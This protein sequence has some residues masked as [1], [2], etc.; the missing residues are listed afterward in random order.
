MKKIDIKLNGGNGPLFIWLSKVVFVVIAV[1]VGYL[2]IS[3]FQGG[4]RITARNIIRKTAQ[5]FYDDSSAV[6]TQDIWR[7]VMCIDKY[8]QPVTREQVRLIKKTPPRENIFLSIGIPTI[9]RNNNGKK[10]DYLNTTLS[11]LISKLSPA[12]RRQV[13]IVIFCADQDP[14]KQQVTIANLQQNFQK[15]IQ[16][17]LIQILLAPKR[18]YSRIDNL[19]RNF[20]DTELRVK[21]RSKQS[22]DIAFMFY[23]MHGLSEFYLHL[24]DDVKTEDDFFETIRHDSKEKFKTEWVMIMYFKMGFI[25]KLIKS[26][27]LSPMADFL[28]N[29]YYEM[30]PDWLYSIFVKLLEKNGVELIGSRTL[31]HHLGVQSSSGNTRK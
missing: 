30:P 5:I 14:K 16:T 8:G 2:L 19:P 9:E 3:S 24:E 21:W 7:G 10:V 15:H 17:G 26:D 23:Y 25:G 12:E 22:L 13:L 4:G 20:N 6:E 1:L 18:F 28:R 29:F 11:I 31:F 27:I